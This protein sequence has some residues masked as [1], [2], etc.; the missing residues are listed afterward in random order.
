MRKLRATQDWNLG[1]CDKRWHSMKLG[2]IFHTNGVERKEEWRNNGAGKIY[3]FDCYLAT[4]SAGRVAFA[5]KVFAEHNDAANLYNHGETLTLTHELHAL[6]YWLGETVPLLFMKDSFN[7]M[8]QRRDLDKKG[9]NAE[10]GW[11]GAPTVWLMNT[12]EERPLYSKDGSSSRSAFSED[13]RGGIEPTPQLRAGVRFATSAVYY[14]LYTKGGPLESI[15]PI[16]SNDRFI[17]RILSTSVRPPHTVASFKRYLCKIEDLAPENCTLY[18]SLTENTALEDSTR[19][20]LRGTPGPGSSVDDPIA[21]ASSN[22]RQSAVE[23]SAASKDLLEQDFE[24]RYVYYHIYDEQGETVSKT[25]FDQNTPSLG[26]VNTLA[27][28]PPHTLA[29]LKNHLIK[30]ENILAPNV[31]IFQDEDSESPLYDT[32]VIALVSNSFLGCTED[33]PIA[34]T[35]EVQGA[36][37]ANNVNNENPNDREA[38]LQSVLNQTREELRKA[39][40][41]I[42]RLKQ[43]HMRELDEARGSSSSQPQPRPLGTGKLQTMRK[44]RAKK[45]WNL[46]DCD[47]RWHSMKLGDIFHTNGVERKEEWRNNGAGKIYSMAYSWIWYMSSR[48]LISPLIQ[49]FDCYLAT[50]SAGRVAFAVAGRIVDSFSRFPHPSGWAK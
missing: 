4:N 21:L 6:Q 29:S 27:I 5:V 42:E 19:L 26:R 30:S 34:V 1:D 11:S 12:N 44:L 25:S 22:E 40:E 36:G 16:Y 3:K 24:Q 10:R 8:Y 38:Q 32:D 41:E 37:V 35:Y 23:S 9:G 49:E 20:S 28:P 33:Q 13:G 50:N 45:D 43:T 14:R 48:T 7:F 18:Q 31:Q 46:G 15:N 39:K 47:K 2:D 17:S